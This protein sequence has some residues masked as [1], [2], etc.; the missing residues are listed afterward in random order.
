M[1]YIVRMENT[2]THEWDRL[3]AGL[4]SKAAKM[5]ALEAAGASRSDIARYLDVSY[6]QVRNTLLR[7]KPS[8]SGFN[9]QPAPFA[10]PDERARV[11]EDGSIR[12]PPSIAAKICATTNDLLVASA[13]EGGLWIATR[14]TGRRRAQEMVRKYIPQGVDLVQDLFD[15]RRREFEKFEAEYAHLDARGQD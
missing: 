5:R 1:V 3:T 12:I 8:R 13:E 10:A 4:P 11:M 15:E 6:Q 2:M 14:E 7:G 9:E